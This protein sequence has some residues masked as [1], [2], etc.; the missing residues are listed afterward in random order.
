MKYLIFTV[1]TICCFSAFSQVD[2]SALKKTQDVLRDSSK[3]SSHIEASSPQAKQALELLRSMG[4]SK[5]QED[6]LFDI[7]ADSFGSM[8]NSV[9]GDTSKLKKQLANGMS[10]PKSF[11]KNMDSRSIDRIRELSSQVEGLNKNERK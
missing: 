3:R 10:D 9:N 4:M 6:A 11:I 1:S 8:M 5:Q 2:Q 7:A